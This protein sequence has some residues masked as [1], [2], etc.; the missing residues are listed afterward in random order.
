M[1][2]DSASVPA[3]AGLLE[4]WGDRTTQLAENR[5]L[6]LRCEMLAE[7]LA[8]AGQWEDAISAVAVGAAVATVRHPGVLGSMR[9]E[10]L[11]AEIAG[12]CL[13][14]LPSRER[15]VSPRRVLHVATELYGVGGHTR[16]L[17]R[18]IGRDAGRS[19]TVLTTAQHAPVV[20][21]VR[22]AATASGGTVVALDPSA[23]WL[24]RAQALREF[25]ADFDVVVLHI[26]H[27]DPVPVLAFAEPQGRPPTVL[28]NHADHMF[29]LGSSIV[30]ALYGGR[31]CPATEDRGI[32]PTRW[33]TGPFPISG[34]DGQVVPGTLG[35][36]ERAEL[37]AQ[38]LQQLG[39]PPDSCLLLTV[40]HPHKYDGPPGTT[41]LDAVLPV[42]TE[43]P[44]AHLLAI[45]CASSADFSRAHAQTG[46]R[47]AGID[48]ASGVMPF[49]AASDVYLESRPMGG[50]GTCAE[51]A[52]SGLPV[53][54]FA[55]SPLEGGV[56][57]VPPQYGAHVATSADEYRELLT[58]LIAAPDR[59]AELARRSRETAFEADR[60]FEATIE[61]AYGTAAECGPAT[62]AE[63]AEPTDGNVPL[64][65]LVEAIQSL[66]APYHPNLSPERAVVALELAARS[67]LVRS[68]FATFCGSARTPELVA[69]VPVAFAA[70][71]ADAGALTALIEEF[72]QLALVGV[73]ERFVV[74]LRPQDCAVAIPAL[75]AALAAGSDVDV[76][77]IV[78]EEPNRVQRPAGSLEVVFG[79]DGGVLYSD[80]LGS[81]DGPSA[82]STV[83][84]AA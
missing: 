76:D 21:Q 35:V 32:A 16:V 27:H 22:A 44:R 28:F 40:G 63:L 8:G 69:R 75:E 10:R 79:S 60:G 59:R 80:R 66:T 45:G 36:A 2:L 46:G 6:L 64:H 5:Q 7:Q 65:T 38:L 29:W 1:A 42:L 68:L 13:A 62:A 58:A 4:S 24:A 17:W 19:H 83:A 18:W 49:F 20:D 47:V 61:R 25:A 73:A 51:A 41:L 11:L 48:A 3:L 30:D 14:P 77:V 33:V 57:V 55:P 56:S 81:G 82:G 34:A 50:V 31:V 78:D 52:L 9:L 39:W 37:R 84:L 70:P 23:P 74:A 26:H 53:L 12:T 67:P 71:P 43:L 72:R 15:A 54:T